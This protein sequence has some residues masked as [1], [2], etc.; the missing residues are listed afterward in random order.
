MRSTLSVSGLQEAQSI[1]GGMDE[2]SIL[3]EICVTVQFLAE[4]MEKLPEDTCLELCRY[5]R[6]E[7]ASKDQVLVRVGDEPSKFCLILTGDLCMHL[8]HIT[9][10]L[11]PLPVLSL[12]LPSTASPRPFGPLNPLPS[13]FAKAVE[14]HRELLPRECGEGSEPAT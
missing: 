14:D 6:L 8:S 11:L 3:D 5:I 12:A 1:M 13:S 9:C 7:T 4:F 2:E 10:D